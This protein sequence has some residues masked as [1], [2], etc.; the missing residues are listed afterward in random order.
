[1]SKPMLSIKESIL[2][3]LVVAVAVLAL[4]F[5]SAMSAFGLFA[6]L[7]VGVAA[8]VLLFGSA[9][10]IYLAVR[11]SFSYALTCLALSAV[12]VGVL[13][14]SYL[15]GV[16]FMLYTLPPTVAI[17]LCLK[18]DRF[19]FQTFF[20]G[21]A[22]YLLGAAL[23]AGFIRLYAGQDILSWALGLFEDAFTNAAPD[24][25]AYRYMVMFGYFD[26]I[27]DLPLGMGTQGFLD[28]MLG[29][30][31]LDA[32]VYAPRALTQI[33]WM[34]NNALPTLLLDI[35]LLGSLVSFGVPHKFARKHMESLKPMKPFSEWELPLGVLIVLAVIGIGATLF[36]GEY[37]DA[38]TM[39]SNLALQMGI[40]LY[41]VIG[42]S[43]AVFFMKKLG[44]TKGMTLL[45]ILMLMM[46]TQFTLVV[47]G[48]VE[49][50]FRLRKRAQQQPPSDQNRP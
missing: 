15:A 33:E 34:M 5:S 8:C 48:V 12:V 32:A 35:S 19:R 38:S 21:F 2:L 42:V 1:L 30:T 13:T 20:I 4:V 39:A 43:T 24:T 49:Q 6:L 46:I 26:S 10:F 9:G 11:H 44:R 3:L 47:L 29:T 27:A 25:E 16:L 40:S 23:I 41:T 22:A 28:A 18:K 7:L 36:A 14:G 17:A 50:C 37:P 45:L 31:V